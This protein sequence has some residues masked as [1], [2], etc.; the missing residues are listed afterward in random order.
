MVSTTSVFLMFVPMCFDYETCVM[1]VWCP[2][3]QC[4]DRMV[5]MTSVWLYGVSFSSRH[6][7]YFCVRIHRAPPW[8]E[9]VNV[10]SNLSRFSNI[11]GFKLGAS[12]GI[13]GEKRGRILA[14]LS[15]SSYK[16]SSLLSK[17]ICNLPL[18]SS[19]WYCLRFNYPSVTGKTLWIVY[20]AKTEKRT[21]TLRVFSP[22]LCQQFPCF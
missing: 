17:S 7:W 4:S 18:R 5:P 20:S 6:K 19:C 12:E 16:V 2:W 13:F 11:F 9:S 8:S 1:T 3:H 22:V 14:R 21:L 15:I 10:L